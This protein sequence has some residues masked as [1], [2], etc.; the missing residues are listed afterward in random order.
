MGDALHI[1]GEFLDYFLKSRL[2]DIR[3]SISDLEYF[4][5]LQSV[6]ENRISNSELYPLLRDLKALKKGDLVG[7]DRLYKL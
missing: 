2:G 4:A 6:I 5:Y 1:T 3:F 7:A